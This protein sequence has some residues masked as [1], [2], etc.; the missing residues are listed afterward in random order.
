MACLLK[1][2]NC[3]KTLKEEGDEVK[4]TRF[5][6][7]VY[8]NLSNSKLREGSRRRIECLSC[9]HMDTVAKFDN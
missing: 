9:G 8:D 6:Y 3:G 4:S 5:S 2:P 1:C 7:R